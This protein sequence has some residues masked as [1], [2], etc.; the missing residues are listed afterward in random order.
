VEP[1][2]FTDETLLR[3]MARSQPEALSELY[4]RYSRLVFSVAFQTLGNREM[5]EEV[6]QDAFLRA[7]Q[8]A[9]SYQPSQGK[10]ATWLASISRHRA[11]DVLRS[12]QSRPEGHSLPL[13][14]LP[15]WDLANGLS[16]EDGLVEAGES[17]RVRAALTQL[18]SDQQKALALAYFYGQTH[19]QIAEA[20]G[21][22]LGTVKTR[23]RLGMQKLRS[24]LGGTE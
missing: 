16:V 15:L 23:I 19:E 13:E 12:Q 20:L 11:I 22:P 10:V 9:A 8:H 18:P 17:Q 21:E 6:T 24:I 3:L 14:D 5:A 4:D 7:W 2:E 1:S